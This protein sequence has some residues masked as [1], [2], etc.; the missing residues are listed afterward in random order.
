LAED[1][2]VFVAEVKR[3]TAHRPAMTIA[4]TFTRLGQ[5]PDQAVV[6]IGPPARAEVR[7]PFCPLREGETRC[8]I[9]G[10]DEH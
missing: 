1:G 5:I 9:F 7:R 3:I 6:A 8:A 10:F 2:T 4:R